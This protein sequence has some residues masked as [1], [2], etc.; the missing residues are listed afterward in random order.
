MAEF[1]VNTMKLNVQISSFQKIEREMNDIVM[2]VSEV[3]RKLSLK[4]SYSFEIKRALQQTNDGIDKEK[5][6]IKSL[7]NCLSDVYS[8]Y[9]QIERAIAVRENTLENIK[10]ASSLNGDTL[11]NNFTS[12]LKSDIFSSAL[13]SSG[14]FIGTLAGKINILTS[15]ARSSGENA[16]V[17]INPNV[18]ETTAAMVKSG[19][20]LIAGAKFGL[21]VIGGIIDFVLLKSG[22]EN[23][24]DA[25]IKSTAHVGIGVAVGAIV[26]SVIPGPGTILG[27]AVGLVAGT[28]LTTAGNFVFDYIYDN[29]D[30]V[31]SNVKKT[32]DDISNKVNGFVS[33]VGEAVN[34]IGNA[35]SSSFLSLGTVFG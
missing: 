28:V 5:C 23:T 20:A 29:W 31:V 27:A 13:K 25:L 11:W 21:P 24:K 22:G 32:A 7:G 30:D 2:K 4:S 15:V 9:D 8:Q 10:E 35:I 18:A 17:I 16:F 3:Q 34:G 26:G 1:E 19:N 33:G 14:G 12:N 6:I